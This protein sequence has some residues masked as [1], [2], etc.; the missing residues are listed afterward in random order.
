[1]LQGMTEKGVRALAQSLFS[2]KPSV[3]CLTQARTLVQ[4]PKSVD[5]SLHCCNQPGCG[6]LSTHKTLVQSSQHENST[7]LLRSSA[8]PI[9]VRLKLFG[10]FQ[11]RCTDMT[12]NQ[13][14]KERD[15]VEVQWD[16]FKSTAQAKSW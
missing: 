13:V 10:S 7:K 3:Q 12:F 1:M 11:S 15:L 8:T 6:R 16:S 14:R 4:Y 2:G 9:G 5:I